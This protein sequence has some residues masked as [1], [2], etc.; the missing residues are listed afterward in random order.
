MIEKMEPCALCGSVAVL[1][2]PGYWACPNWGCLIM[3][4]SNDTDGTRW[5][6]LMRRE[7]MKADPIAPREE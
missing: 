1:K 3:G 4:P 5:N 7:P 2:V 6:R